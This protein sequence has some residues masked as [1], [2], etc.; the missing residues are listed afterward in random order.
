MSGDPRKVELSFELSLS[1]V[2]AARRYFVFRWSTLLVFFLTAFAW[3]VIEGPLS[4]V[5]WIGVFGGLFGSWLLYFQP[6]R[7][8][9]TTPHL[10]GQHRWVL[11]GDGA[12]FEATDSDGAP[13]VSSDL[14]WN[15][16]TSVRETDRAFLLGGSKSSYFLL[17]K[18][19]LDPAA[20]AEVRDLLAANVKKA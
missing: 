7:A 3:A 10:R 1:D 11:G 4:A 18:R 19:G 2:L 17:P 5:L 9:R 8:F 6:R 20:V 16:V 14:S 12:S 13:L 15:Y